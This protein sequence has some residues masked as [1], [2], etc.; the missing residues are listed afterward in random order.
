M[1]IGS[2]KGASHASKYA[3]ESAYFR[4]QHLVYI[5]SIK[6]VQKHSSSLYIMYMY[7]VL[8]IE[9]LLYLTRTSTYY[10]I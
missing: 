3:T 10:T 6:L 7:K 4:Q 2:G 8:S 5:A 1:R 9:T